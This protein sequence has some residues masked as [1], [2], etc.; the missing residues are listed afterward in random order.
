METQ[1]WMYKTQRRIARRMR[2]FKGE[3]HQ[4][5]SFLVDSKVSLVDLSEPRLKTEATKLDVDVTYCAKGDEAIKQSIWGRVGTAYHSIG[6]C[7]IGKPD[8]MGVLD[9]NL[10]VWGV[11]RLKVADLSIVPKNLSGNTMSTALMIGEKAADIFIKEL[12]LVAT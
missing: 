2:F 6:T 1:V 11:Q 12:K 3:T 8:G 4:H 10:G 9:P 5:P 7:K